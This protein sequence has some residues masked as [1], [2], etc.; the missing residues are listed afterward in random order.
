[1]E[2]ALEKTAKVFGSLRR[3]SSAYGLKISH[4]GSKNMHARKAIG[5]FFNHYK[6]IGVCFANAETSH[7]IL[8]H[9]LAHFLDARA[10]NGLRHFFASDRADTPENRIAKTFRSEMNK[11]TRRTKNS[12]Y[13]NRTCECFA[14]AME[15]Y[16]AFV[17]SPAQYENFTR[18]ESYTPDEP[19]RTEIIPLIDTVLKERYPLWHGEEALMKI[20]RE[21]LEAL[22]KEAQKITEDYKPSVDLKKMTTE[23]LADFIRLA[24]RRKKEYA[25]T[26]QKTGEGLK[27]PE[28]TVLRLLVESRRGAL[29]QSFLETEYA[30]RQERQNQPPETPGVEPLTV[31]NFKKKFIQKMADPKAGKNVINTLK[32]VMKEFTPEDKEKMR[33]HLNSQGFNNPAIAYAMFNAWAKEA[34]S[35][36]AKA[37]DHEYMG[38]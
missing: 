28:Q 34:R 31:E 6:A 20:E 8:S 33:E 13:L 36:P 7:L 5:I 15:Q 38:R 35:V 22:E 27:T 9:E 10:G 19:F 14:R 23:D 24:E 12:K 1:V 17:L 37:K 11:N 26:I 3:V 2:E 25:E 29:F 16:T 21:T 4:A 32:L 30:G 18:S